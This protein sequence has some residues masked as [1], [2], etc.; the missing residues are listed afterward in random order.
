[1]E[2]FD[3]SPALR[4]IYSTSEP[5]EPI[6]LYQGSL[7][8]TQKET[9]IKGNGTLCIRWLPSPNVRFEFLSHDDLFDKI[10][11]DKASLKLLDFTIPVSVEV[12]ILSVPLLRLS[13]ENSILGC[14]RKEAVIL[15]SGQE[16]SYILFH[17][18][19][20]NDFIGT[21]ISTISTAKR[22][23][24]GRVVL[25]AEGWLITIDT[26]ENCRDIIKSLKSQGGYAITHVGKLERSNKQAFTV[27]KA[28]ELLKSLYWFLLFSGGRR[29]FPILPV[30]YNASGEKVWKKWACSYI[31]TPWKEG[32]YSWF[33]TSAPQ[34]LSE[35]FP[36]FL[37][38]WQNS[39][40]NEPIRNSIHWY[41]ESN[42]QAGAITGS[43][44]LTQAALELL[45]WVFLVEEKGISVK[46][47]K[48]KEEYDSTSKKINRL[49]EELGI[50]QKIPH[51]L[52]KL[53]EFEKEL[54]HS[55]NNGPYA[56]TEMRNSIVH[57]APE[58]RV[59]LRNISYETK[60][61]A[62]QLGLCYL[63]LVLLCLFEYRGTYFNRVAKR[64]RSYQDNIKA[65]PW[66]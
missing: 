65:V 18:V 27:E 63:E 1:M 58:N 38:K 30:G 17:L 44:I 37:C 5:N 54:K 19:N 15:Q 13:S 49:F 40:W 20:F 21:W 50:H 28:D 45:A 14:L 8:I 35:V 66:T 43:I 60:I 26:L 3:S 24:R 36:G 52:S 46:E 62:Y 25:E 59:K 48:E 32:M 11:A 57:A 31:A 34:S 22:A 55:K 51:S 23:W 6:Q 56:L 9:V 16:L 53:T 7:E 12:Y 33:P 42:A 61:E 64:R 4:P 41:L 29:T 10:S 2:S 39:T 47:F